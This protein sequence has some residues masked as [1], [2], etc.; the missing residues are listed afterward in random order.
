MRTESERQRSDALILTLADSKRMM[1]IRYSDWILGAP[2][3]EAGIAASSMS[4][5]EW[6]HAR[7][8]YAM[9][10]ELG[11]DPVAVE[12]D[13]PAEAYASLDALDEPFDN[14]ADVVAGMVLLDGALSVALEG[15]SEGSFEFAR[16]RIPKMMQEER[17]HADLGHA[18]VQAYCRWCGGRPDTARGG[19]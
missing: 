8:I 13:R 17:Y 4:Q 11:E 2:S 5:D 16:N 18:L 10:K 19:R 3:V 9:L 1:G 7:L 12:H 15:F 14:W 6:G